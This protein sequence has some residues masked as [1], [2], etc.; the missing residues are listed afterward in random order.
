MV[1]YFLKSVFKFTIYAF[2]YSLKQDLQEQAREIEV[3]IPT[4]S[5]N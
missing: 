1:E 2:F 5:M 4:Y 3:K